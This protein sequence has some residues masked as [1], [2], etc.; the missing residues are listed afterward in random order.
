M[1]A[2]P[3]E[4]LQRKEKN[5]A[6]REKER[7]FYELRDQGKLAKQPEVCEECGGTKDDVF[8]YMIE[9]DREFEGAR[10]RRMYYGLDGEARR[11][12]GDCLTISV[13][14]GKRFRQLPGDWD[15]NAGDDSEQNQK[16]EQEF[17]P[18]KSVVK[19]Y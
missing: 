3:A 8:W 5:R 18:R 11:L 1:G 19:F 17:A 12:C 9:L 6:K 14:K 10:I 13:K 2:L 7:R 16:I 4:I 15:P